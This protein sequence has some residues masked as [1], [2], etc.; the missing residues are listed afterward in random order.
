MKW[1][2]E[3][4]NVRVPMEG[5]EQPAEVTLF[6]PPGEFLALVGPNRA[7]KSLILKLCV[8]LVAFEEGTI[9]VL[10]RDLAALDDDELSELRRRIGVVLQPPGLRSNMTVYTNVALPIVY[11]TGVD[12]AD[13]RDR[14][15]PVLDTFGLALRQ[16]H[17]PAQ[18]TAGEARCA[19]LARAMIMNPEL[20]LIDEPAAGLDAEGVLRVEQALMEYRRA[21]PVTIVATMH[22]P[23][24]LLQR[25]DRI[26]F[27]R[28]GRIEATGRYAELAEGPDG[29]IKP[30][31]T[32]KLVS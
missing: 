22:T 24:S 31:L 10:D 5:G 28:G 18:L 32:G 7:G 14:V 17:F 8:G 25:A 15:M 2:I 1:A 19:A 12:Y 11:H 26:A 16:D 20:L 30:Y 6:V 23:S 27:V 21:H 4:N 13:L 29:A 3:L 9:R